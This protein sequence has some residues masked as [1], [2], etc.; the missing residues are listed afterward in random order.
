MYV[1]TGPIGSHSNIHVDVS[2]DGAQRVYTDSI[3]RA[4]TCGF[5]PNDKTVKPEGYGPNHAIAIDTDWLTYTIRFQ[6]TGTDTAFT[7]VIR[8]SLDTH[9]DWARLSIVAV[10]HPLTSIVVDEGG[11]ATFRF[12]QINLPDSNVNEPASH[13]FIKY[14]IAPLSGVTD[15]TQLFN[16]AS[17][18]FDLNA[19]VIT[20]TISNTLVDCNLFTAQINFD[21]NDSLA[22]TPG[23]SYQWFMNGDSIQG[24]T[25]QWLIAGSDGNYYVA[26]TNINGC[27]ALSDTVQI[28]TG[29]K[30]IHELKFAVSPNPSNGNFDVTCNEECDK[31]ELSDISGR[32]IQSFT[33]KKRVWHITR[34]EA[35]EAGVYIIHIFRNGQQ[36]GVARLIIE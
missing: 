10:S 29:I 3:G 12:D 8:D 24:A 22:A 30:E 13:G 31:I 27:T 15:G 5:D 9:L 25:S 19:P 26:V 35:L 28:I 1:H 2:W 32:V 33:G 11:L 6:N 17:I 21:G 4:I 14:R 23:V 16:T 34:S 36:P 20:N 18:Y 7:V